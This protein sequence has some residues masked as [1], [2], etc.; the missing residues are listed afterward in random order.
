MKRIL[1]FI[2]CL[3]LLAGCVAAT[4]EE[5]DVTAPSLRANVTDDQAPT[6]DEFKFAENGKT[7]RKGDKVH[8]SVKLTDNTAV[9]YGNVNF[10]YVDKNNRAY[11]VYVY[12]SYNAQTDRWE[13]ENELGSNLANGTYYVSSIQTED[14]YGN[15]SEIWTGSPDSKIGKF[16]FKGASKL[17]ASVS[18]KENG[19][20]VG[21][22]DPLHITVK[23]KK[24]IEGATT[25]EV[26]FEN[27]EMSYS[28]VFWCYLDEA[29]GTFKSR[30]DTST[31]GWKDEK[32]KIR[33]TTPDGEYEATRITFYPSDG[34]IEIGTA[35]VSG[36][37]VTLSG[38]KKDLNGPTISSVKISPKGKTVAPGTT[39]HVKAKIKDSSKVDKA[40]AI[41]LNTDYKSEWDSK[42][43]TGKYEGHANYSIVLQKTSGNNWEGDY[44]IPDTTVNGTYYLE[45]QANDTLYNYSWKSFDKQK[46]NVKGE[47]V[48][49]SG[50]TRFVKDAYSILLDRP[51]TDDEAAAMAKRI[52]ERKIR[53]VDVVYEIISQA[54]GLSDQEKAARLLSFMKGDAVAAE[55]DKWA[56]ALA[57][58]VSLKAVIDG[59]ADSAEFRDLCQ[60]NN[61]KVGSLTQPTVTAIKLNKKKLSLKVGKSA[62]LKATIEPAD[63]ANKKLIW[64]SSN[65]GVAKVSQKG[66]VTAVG[67]GECTI[68]CRS[69][70]GGARI[71]ITVK[72]K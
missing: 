60:K 34:G 41:F 68:T 65:T 27:T 59:I 42:K 31:F 52:A 22:K 70:D 25:A 11:E 9:R 55:V 18:L 69:A 20:T 39:V 51:A 10:L 46:F 50:M 29:T 38:G 72:V 56:Q 47:D 6:I 71:E 16:K 30:E 67:V 17:K 58:G 5:S 1:A 26:L 4:G 62:T 7:L 43:K 21:P 44:V 24:K 37:S 64:S 13:G 3:F 63:A 61:V 57:G 49:S 15:Y 32:G 8:V 2:L 48:A 35:D 66:K 36:Q 54:S 53:G 28:R 12:L 33:C 40:Y 23:P 14:I 45:I 19:K